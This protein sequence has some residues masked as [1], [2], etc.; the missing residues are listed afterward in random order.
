ML[1]NLLLVLLD[2][3]NYVTFF[4]SYEGL[5]VPFPEQILSEAFSVNNLNQPYYTV[6]FLLSILQNNDPTLNGLRSKYG[7]SQSG[8]DL[9]G[10]LRRL[11]YNT[12]FASEWPYHY[13]E[14]SFKETSPYT[15]WLVS[16]FDRYIDTQPSPDSFY[17]FKRLL[18]ESKSLFEPWAL[19]VQCHDTHTPF[20][21]VGVQNW[22][23][24][25]DE[26]HPLIQERVE[27]HC[28]LN[29]LFTSGELK[30]DDF[31]HKDE[32]MAIFKRARGYQFQAIRYCMKSL[33]DFIDTQDNLIYHIMGDHPVFLGEVDHW[34]SP[35]GPRITFENS[36]Q[37][38][39]TIWI[40]NQELDRK[41][42][43]FVRDFH[44]VIGRIL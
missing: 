16:N 33:Q 39:R 40:T 25:I 27:H 42:K 22:S 26:I 15:R 4:Q 12:T 19:V 43:Y 36:P 38:M 29:P 18:R 34:C 30:W 2:S 35:Y 1:P 17:D 23:P 5:K 44:K 32:I 8:F 13:S 37:I 31:T 3:V 10:C 20:N 28:E 7:V 21:S 11:G 6:G 41:E 9:L 24:W 14:G